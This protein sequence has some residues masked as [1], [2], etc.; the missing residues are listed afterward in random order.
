MLWSF[1]SSLFGARFDGYVEGDD[2]IFAVWDGPVAPQIIFE[3][4]GFDLKIIEQPDPAHASFCG[5]VFASHIIRDPFVFFSKFGWTY[6]AMLAGMRVRKQLLRA[7]ALSALYETP[8]C[9]IVH[10][11]AR[12]ALL[13]TRGETPRYDSSFYEKARPKDEA[14]IPESNPTM[15]DRELFAEL[16]NV[17]IP[18]QIEVET[19]FLSG[20]FNVTDLLP[21]SIETVLNTTL[22]V[23]V[24]QPDTT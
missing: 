23:S 24:I 12:R 18:V 4:M 21:P 1:T 5:M 19:R 17:S 3:R 6:T 7:K 2:G 13:E 8:S 11:L 20:N 9:P 14:E 22:V 10:A 16:Y 15:E